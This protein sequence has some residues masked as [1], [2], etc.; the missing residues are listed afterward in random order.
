MT[1][2][3]RLPVPVLSGRAVRL[4]TAAVILSGGCR[5]GGAT[6]GQPQ[7]MPPI[8]EVLE[9]HTDSLLSVPGV[10][11]VAEGESGGRPVIRVFVERRTRELEARLP[12]A[13]EGYPVVVVESGEI[14]ARDSTH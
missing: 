8:A 5:T 13:L 12:R 1:D 14:Q 3:G 7:G 6:A 10:V 9:R 11:G 2:A 4:M